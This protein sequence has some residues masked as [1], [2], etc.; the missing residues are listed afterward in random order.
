M[1]SVFAF[2]LLT[3]FAAGGIA[4]MVYAFRNSPRRRERR[5]LRADAE[6]YRRALEEQERRARIPFP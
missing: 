3:I 5:R 6:E 1:E 2:V 4:A